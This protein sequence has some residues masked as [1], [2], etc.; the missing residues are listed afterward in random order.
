MNRRCVMEDALLSISFNCRISAVLINSKTVF[1]LHH[2]KVSI[3]YF[4]ISAAKQNAAV[5]NTV[6]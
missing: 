6:F 2:Y 4:H 1:L 3:F 5:G